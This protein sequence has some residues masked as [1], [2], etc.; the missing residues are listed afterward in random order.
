MKANQ[1]NIIKPYKYYGQW[2]FDDPSVE[3]EREAF[4]A[5]ADTLLDTVTE[6]ILEIPNA[7]DGIIVLFS[8]GTFPSYNVLL[9]WQRGDEEGNFYSCFKDNGQPITTHNSYEPLE[10]WLCPALFK[11]YEEAPREL[12]MQVKPISQVRPTDHPKADALSQR[13]PKNSTS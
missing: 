2:V 9:K 6:N 8:A 13:T 11:Y 4:V 7:E 1:I 3:L 10:A 5:G 12:Y